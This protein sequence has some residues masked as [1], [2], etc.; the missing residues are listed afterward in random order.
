MVTYITYLLRGC[1]IDS[2]THS[3]GWKESSETTNQTQYHL[4][5]KPGFVSLHCISLLYAKIKVLRYVS[6]KKKWSSSGP[7]QS[8]TPQILGPH[9]RSQDAPP[10][11]SER[12][13]SNTTLGGASPGCRRTWPV[14]KHNG[15]GGWRKSSGFFI[16][17]DP[18]II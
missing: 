7:F 1:Y 4:V 10:Y 17:N 14:W 11:A 3:V 16:L 18:N 2:I 8:T 5:D 9:S 15:H 13:P 12:S 6:P